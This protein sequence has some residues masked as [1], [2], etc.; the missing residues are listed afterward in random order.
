MDIPARAPPA[1]SRRLLIRPPSAFRS[2]IV[3]KFDTSNFRKT[4]RR[5]TGSR[6]RPRPPPTIGRVDATLELDA[7]Y[8]ALREEAGVIDRSERPRIVVR[9]AEAAEFLQ[10]QITNDVEALRPGQ[11]CY[12]ALLDRKGKV[13]ADMRVLRIAEDEFLIDTEPETGDQL[14]GHLGMYNVGRDAEVEARRF[15]AG[16]AVAARPADA[17]AARRR[18][19]RPGALP[20]GAL[21]R[22]R[23]VPRHR[24]RRRR[25]RARSSRGCRGA[26]RLT[27][28]PRARSRSPRT[29]ARSPGSSPGDRGSGARSAR[30]RCP[31]RPR[32]TS[33]R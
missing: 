6:A 26:S 8:R 1:R 16:P 4:V 19:A 30:R 22:G 20:L 27:C 31:P 18:A 15:R 25:R 29:P 11:G 2:D 12:A 10:G 13:R 5:P 21:R 23:R 17:A 7:Q 28:S 9:G 24:H 14:A 33:A 32:S 3:R